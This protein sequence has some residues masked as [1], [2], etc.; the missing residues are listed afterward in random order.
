MCRW[1][2]QS[3]YQP[4]DASPYELYH[5]NHEEHPEK[6]FIVDICIPVKCSRA[7]LNIAMEIILFAVKQLCIIVCSL[8]E[9][10]IELSRLP[11]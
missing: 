10:G 11:F 5:N 7:V 1:V 9:L 4:A 6:K 2:A 8:V 3:G